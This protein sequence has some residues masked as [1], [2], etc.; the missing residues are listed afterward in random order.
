MDEGTIIGCVTLCV[1][2]V[3]VRVWRRYFFNVSTDGRGVYAPTATSEASVVSD[4]EEKAKEVEMA[5]IVPVSIVAGSHDRNDL[6][7]ARPMS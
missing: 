3:V 6:P 4:D 7:E 2:F 5:T 1:I